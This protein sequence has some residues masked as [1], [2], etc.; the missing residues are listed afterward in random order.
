M[1]SPATVVETMIRS[2]L[3][4]HAPLFA[5]VGQNVYAE[6]VPDTTSLPYIVS[7]HLSG[8]QDRNTEYAMMRYKVQGVTADRLM[9]ETLR[10]HIHDALH[11]AEGV[12]IGTACLVQMSEAMPVFD[13]FVVQNNPIFYAG[14]IFDVIM[15]LS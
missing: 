8:G 15:R 4:A 10:G 9:A 13:R 3:V 1:T 2:T 11:Y 12:T 5:I 6:H 7:F 14:G